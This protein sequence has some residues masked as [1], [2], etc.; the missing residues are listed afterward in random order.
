MATC[1]GVT[2]HDVLSAN[3]ENEEPPLQQS[4]TDGADWV[5]GIT[6]GSETHRR[7]A[8]FVSHIWLGSDAPL[9]TLSRTGVVGR[10]RLS[11]PDV[12]P[13]EARSQLQPASME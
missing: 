8:T 6:E 7:G 11:E 3:Q 1:I 2:K 13:Q 12:C 5:S 4:P 10:T 9:A